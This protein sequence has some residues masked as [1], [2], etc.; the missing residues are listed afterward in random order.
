MA[1]AHP[2]TIARLLAARRQP[3]E[4]LVAGLT[5]SVAAGKSTLAAAIAAELAQA[6]RVELLSTDGF[7]LPNAILDAQ[8]LTMRKGFPE[9]YDIP[10]FRSV[11]QDARRGPVTVPGYSHILYDIDPGLARKIDRPDILLVEGLG[12]APTA[13]GPG[14]SAALDTLIYLDAAEED[15]QHWFLERFMRL[16]HA[17][18]EDPA[19]FYHRFRPLGEEGAREFA[20]TAVWEGINLPNLRD[21]IIHARPAA[22][23]LVRKHCDHSLELLRPV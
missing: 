23:I 16:W 22:D 5:G 4:V 2:S 19:S 3:G 20:R 21:H 8:G 9:S 6:H 7:L 12:L 17:A 13:D 15:L 14:A 10:A 11:L 18:A 1:A